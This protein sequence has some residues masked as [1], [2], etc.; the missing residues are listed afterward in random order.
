M[1]SPGT[2]RPSTA[3][4][5]RFGPFCL[6]PGERVLLENDA[7][8]RL[9]HRAMDILLLLVSR[10]GEFIPNDE[11]VSHV[12]PKSVVVE[13]N[14]RVH[15][16]ALRKA[17]GYGG[18]GQRYIINVP[19]RGYSFIGT[20]SRVPAPTAITGSLGPRVAT[21]LPAP[22]HRVIGRETVI[23]AVN[24]LLR[25]HRLVTLVGAGGIGKTT[26]AVT[27]AAGFGAPSADLPWKAV[28]FVDLSPLADPTLVPSA[29]AGALGLAAVVENAIP[30]LLAYLHDKSMLL[31]LDSCE[32]VVTA[33]AE[34]AEAILRGAPGVHVLATSREPLRAEG[35]WIQRLQAL[36]LPGSS[37]HSTAREALL[38][39]A[40]EL[41][42]EH[43]SAILG[44]FEFRD[45]DVATVVEICRRLDGIPLAI[46]LAAA[47]IDT[48]GIRGI[49]SALDDCFALLNKGR[50]TALPR[51]QTLQAT[52]DWSYRLLSLRDQSV[53]L[54]LS[55]F[56]GSFTLDSACAVAAWGALTTIDVQDGVVD[57]VAKSLISAD[58]SGEEAYFR[59]LDTTR[60]YAAARLARND[61]AKAMRRRHAEHCLEILK[62]AEAAWRSA[63]AAAWLARYGRHV[64]DVRAALRWGHAPG[65]DVGLAIAIAAKSA[66]LFFQLSF[67]D[68]NR[69]HAQRAMDALEQMGTV[70]PQL[71]F[72]L[73]I[74]YGHALFHTRGIH[75]ASEQA[76]ARALTLAE[77]NGDPVQL[78]LAYST[79]WMGA[80]TRGEPRAMRDYAQKFEALTVNETDPALTVLPDRMMSPTLHFLGDQRGS[81]ACSERSL[82]APLIRSSF[83][84]GAQIDRRVSMGAILARTLWLQGL[85]EQ[86]E[87]VASRTID[88]AVREGESVALAFV[89]AQCACPLAFWMGDI[90][91]ARRRVA[92]L[93]RHTYEHSLLSWRVYAL[94]Y[95][96]L[97][98]WYE[99]GGAGDP[100]EPNLAGPI[101]P[102]PTLIELLATL[103]PSYAGDVAF[104]RGKEGDA[105]WCLAELLRVQGE[106]VRQSDP[107][108]AE[109]FLMQSLEIAQRDGTLAWELRTSASVARLWAATRKESE[110]L[111]RLDAVL[112]RVTEGFARP[113]VTAAA[114]LR[115][116]IAKPAAG[117]QP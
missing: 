31:V 112:A 19:N 20:L 80:Y 30:S 6:V 77:R 88:V 82:A 3:D 111:L 103:H 14:L 72:E 38:F 58:I 90:A 81:R 49:A 64:D 79:N 91:L 37:P 87:S 53:L 69:G 76:F 2:S 115:E 34:L 114:Q 95:E 54:R 1:D 43:A 117:R 100:V 7:P 27:V 23:E 47:R 48:L 18:D 86:A 10:A 12:W 35:E 109:R 96:P 50:R 92:L 39:G 74:V 17:L 55:V 32:H 33:A 68:E 89:L 44:S 73:N 59:L 99:G 102:H 97:L 56:A 106:R 110:A 85:P 13:G 41:F 9:G 52:L 22:L 15:L 25:K 104:R 36:A 16:V 98:A 113:D 28:H 101:L 57:L 45:E 93:L 29:L 62:S 70:D 61:D 11:I 66:P 26:V 83:L 108:A 8:V 42:V 4:A 78:A 116:R 84:S 107:K 40:I 46:E 67:A 75:P 60:A 94:A 65:G 5:I 21:G 51:H 24:G 63:P 71:E 105:G